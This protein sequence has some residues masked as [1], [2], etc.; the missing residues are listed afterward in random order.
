PQEIGHDTGYEIENIP[1]GKDLGEILEEKAKREARYEKKR[2][3]YYV[4]KDMAKMKGRF[5]PEKKRL[6]DTI[7]NSDLERLTED[8]RS[9]LEKTADKIISDLADA[10]MP[11]KK[12]LMRDLSDEYK[13]TNKT[14]RFLYDGIP[15]VYYEENVNGVTRRWLYNDMEVEIPENKLDM[16]IM[17]Q[18]ELND[19]A[20]TFS[21]TIGRFRKF[22]NND[23]IREEFDFVE[24]E[25][26]P[27]VQEFMRA[28]LSLKTQPFSWLNGLTQWA[29][30]RLPGLAESASIGRQKP[31]VIERLSVPLEGINNYANYKMTGITDYLHNVLQGEGFTTEA[32]HKLVGRIFLST[33]VPDHKNPYKWMMA[34]DTDPQVRDFVKIFEKEHPQVFKEILYWKAKLDKATL[35]W[36]GSTGRDF[37]V[38]K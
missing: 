25:D 31:E 26:N 20:T 19:P 30:K 11:T 10:K 36:V 21:G 33:Y 5:T 4:A 18:G 15:F 29:T 2:L 34:R 3:A 1:R 16:P 14:V 38:W 22:S 32:S 6:I 9:Q 17:I 35:D 28:S 24:K 8:A 27:A 12:I 7:L 13:K 23:A 37:D